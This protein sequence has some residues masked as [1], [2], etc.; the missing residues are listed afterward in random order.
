LQGRPLL[1]SPSKSC[2]DRSFAAVN[3]WR[4][5]GKYPKSQSGTLE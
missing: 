3:G 4:F 5:P 1:V 2:I